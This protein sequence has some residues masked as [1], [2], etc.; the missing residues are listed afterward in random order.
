[1]SA[2]AAVPDPYDLP[3][4]WWRRH[5]DWVWAVAVGVLTAGLTVMMFPPLNAP[6]L[7][8]GF[9]VP[10]IYWAYRSPPFRLYAGTLLAAQVVAWT[11]LLWWLRHVTWVGLFLLGPFVGVLVG[12]WYLAVWWTMRRLVGRPPA[13]RIAGLLGL[14]GVWVLLEWLRTW[15]L[16]GFP[17]LPLAASQWQRTAL[18]QIASFTGAYGI[19]FILIFFNLGFAT[20]GWRMLTSNERGLFRRSPEFS[21]A[22]FVLAAGTMLPMAGA[23]NRGRFEHR[24]AAVAFVQPY[25]PQEVKW[26]PARGP[27][28]L[29]TL[30]EATQVAAAADPDFILWP[31][32]TTPWAV[33]GDP[34]TRAWI[35]GLAAAAKAPLVLGSIAIEHR[36]QPDE[37]WYNGMFV[38]TPDLGEQTAWYA[39]R[40]LVPF[41]EYIP[42]RPLLGWLSKVVPI[43]DDFTPGDSA[44]PLLVP[45][46]HESLAAG[47][48]I[49]FEDIFP[50]LAR[51]DV[52]DG[53]DFLFVATNSAWYGEGGAA[54]QH[55]AHSVLRA[56]ETRRPVLRCGNSGWSG[57]IDEFG[58]IRGVLTNPDGS[59]YT[60]GVKTLAVRRDARWTGRRS[61]YVEHGD[62]FVA[63]CA[64][65]VGLGWLGAG[66]GGPRPVRVRPAG[67]GALGRYPLQRPEA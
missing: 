27:A 34:R 41:G 15:F 45:V 38:V 61:F 22:L 14:A 48:L 55:A 29:R 37:K 20:S 63:V 7:A 31:E 5:A 8:Y 35:E 50:A 56:V 39:K 24:L 44:A 13:L 65:L 58:V 52:R 60:R 10:A 59:I 43:G 6:E 28:I 32:A 12:S 57:W 46:R 25:I 36:G 11:V 4:P 26:D 54:Y 67:E 30:E 2:P 40:H 47:P 51:A 19:S 33:R 3:D 64:G 62:W 21:F 16:G 42:L 23:F 18:L 1:M 49:C 17:W 66:P 9:A 53:A